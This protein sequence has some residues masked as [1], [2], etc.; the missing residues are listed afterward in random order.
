MTSVHS[1]ARDLSPKY[2]T[3]V[4]Y[5]SNFPFEF[6]GSRTTAQIPQVKN[7]DLINRNTLRS[8]DILSPS[9]VSS[10]SY[11]RLSH[12]GNFMELAWKRARKGISDA[13]NANRVSDTQ[14]MTASIE[15]GSSLFNGFHDQLPH[16]S[17][18]ISPT[19]Q[20]GNS[21]SFALKNTAFGNI[22]TVV[23]SNSND[24]YPLSKCQPCSSKIF[25]TSITTPS[26]TAY[27]V[28]ISNI[29][30]A[31]GGIL[32]G[33]PLRSNQVVKFSCRLSSSDRTSM[34]I[35]KRK[36]SNS[37][38]EGHSCKGTMYLFNEE[39]AHLEKPS[40][41]GELPSPD[42]NIERMKEKKLSMRARVKENEEV[43]EHTYTGHSSWPSN[44]P[45]KVQQHSSIWL[46]L[47]ELL[48]TATSMVGIYRDLNISAEFFWFRS[49]LSSHWTM[50][51]IWQVRFKP[52]FR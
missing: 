29:S 43:I 2:E 5:G 51:W 50:K 25:T 37:P 21:H 44:I 3:K 48:Y 52:L 26:R 33:T 31:D 14:N 17:S 15:C 4:P 9:S 28:P 42:I 36:R 16:R 23:P 22:R 27:G 6:N 1:Y 19:I 49:Q 39:E 34:S 38:L 47:Y 35:Q 12:N 8:C 18:F 10:C 40:S 20:S 24:V 7:D 11:S 45:Q 30:N 32:S 46:K 13:D 41:S